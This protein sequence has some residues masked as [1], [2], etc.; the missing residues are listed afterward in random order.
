[1]LFRHERAKATPSS[2]REDGSDAGNTEL[3]CLLQHDTALNRKSVANN[4]ASDGYTS[5]STLSRSR[6]ILFERAI[7]NEAGLYLVKTQ[8]DRECYS[9][10]RFTRIQ[11]FRE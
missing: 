3:L 5:R 6:P 4:A 11:S 8:P 9:E 10:H 1:M 7:P 2:D